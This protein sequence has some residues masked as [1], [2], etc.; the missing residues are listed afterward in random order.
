MGQKTKGRLKMQITPAYTKL[1][2]NV[3]KNDVFILNGVTVTVQDVR[4]K[5]QHHAKIVV[6]QY[7]TPKLE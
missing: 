5:D 6:Y 1:P 2:K 7:E 3:E 4:H